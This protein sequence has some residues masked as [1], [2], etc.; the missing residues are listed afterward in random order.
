MARS[1]EKQY[2]KTLRATLKS[3]LNEKL[4]FQAIN[5]WVVP[6]L[7]FGA[8][9]INWTNEELKE[10]DRKTRNIVTMYGKLVN[11]IRDQ[12]LIGCTYQE[13]KE[14]GGLTKT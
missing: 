5:I 2:F 13:V 1:N 4:V 8:G 14:V 12:I 9:I 6:N 3:K 11:Y 7:P 10:M